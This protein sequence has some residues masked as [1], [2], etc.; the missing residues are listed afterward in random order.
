ME[1]SM[2]R[3]A[4]LGLLAGAG[5]LTITAA[6]AAVPIATPGGS[7]MATS[8]P[9]NTDDM[10][11]TNMASQSPEKMSPR[12]TRPQTIRQVQRFLAGDGQKVKIDGVWGPA[13]EAA[14]KNYQKQDGL[15][16]TGQLDQATQTQMNLKS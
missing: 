8:Q 5:L 11:N 14:L 2:N 12:P 1:F 7:N 10:A 15:T 9:A 4:S 16:V 13:T 6:N 3:I